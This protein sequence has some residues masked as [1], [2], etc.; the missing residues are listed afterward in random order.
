LPGRCLEGTESRRRVGIG[1][2]KMRIWFL[3]SFRH[4]L[5]FDPQSRKKSNSL[6][7][8]LVKIDIQSGFDPT[9]LAVHLRKT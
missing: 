3:L 7:L 8:V 2:T 6:K 9:L 1:R 4:S 5:H